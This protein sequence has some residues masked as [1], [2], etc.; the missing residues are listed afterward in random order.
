MHELTTKTYLSRFVLLLAVTLVLLFLIHSLPVSSK[1]LTIKPLKD[2]IQIKEKQ[3]V[4][5]TVFSYE[6]V[7][8]TLYVYDTIFVDSLPIPFSFAK[9]DAAYQSIKASQALKITDSLQIKAF[10][11]PFGWYISAGT[12]AFFFENLTSFQSS[13][14]ENF[15]TDFSSSLHPVAG[16]G[17][18]VNLGKMINKRWGFQTGISYASYHEKFQFRRNFTF[19]DSIFSL[20]DT[21]L[22]T[23]I[24]DT[25]V[26]YNLDALLQGDSTVYVEYPYSY[27]GAQHQQDTSW[28]RTDSLIN[29]TLNYSSSWS[30]L[31]VPLMATYSLPS[32]NQKVEIMA[33]LVPSWLL[34]QDRYFLF[35]DAPIPAARVRTETERFTL[36]LMLAGNWNIPLSG[37]FDFTI[38]PWIKIPLYQ[39]N[40]SQFVTSRQATQGLTIGIRYRF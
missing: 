10:I 14:T 39:Y 2:T 20:Y 26:I 34:R 15:K 37:K 35:P 4:Y 5:D 25:V 13:Q 36:Q 8:D 32:R 30:L 17:I 1:D 27:W 9:K 40:T 7:Y 12:G 3:I 19:E 38:K 23:Q 22:Y 28:V 6:Y 18:E 24:Y 11:P 21:T 16:Y 31:E 29:D 33:G